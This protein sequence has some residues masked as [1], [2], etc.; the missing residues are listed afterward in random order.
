MK[1]RATVIGALVVSALSIAAFNVAG[2]SAVTM[3]ECTTSG[4]EKT[5]T[6]SNCQ[7]EGA[8]SFHT[9]PVA[10]NEKVQLV[11]TLT[12]TTGTNETH[13]VI[14][15]VLAGVK[16]K[17]TATGLTSTNT[18]AKNV[19]PSPG[20]MKVEGTGNVAFTGATLVEPAG[21]GCTV[22]TE[23]STEALTFSTNEM[24]GTFKPASGETFTTFAISGCTGGAAVLNGSKTARG[25]ATATVTEAKP[26]SLGFTET[27]G[28]NISFGG[29]PAVF[30]G[31]IH[32]STAG[33]TLVSLETP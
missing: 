27:S 16:Y 15:G 17:I 10:L 5:Y 24:A 9:K 29:Q 22:P 19:E 32:F 25:S 23:I 14:R 8:G 20:N 31:V 26:T 11:P 1:C 30:E 18:E 12:P 4:T 7:T 21:K 28:S 2:A 13:I 6:T 33:G 3:H